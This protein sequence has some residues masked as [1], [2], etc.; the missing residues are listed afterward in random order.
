MRIALTLIPG[1]TALT[2]TLFWRWRR[3]LFASVDGVPAKNR[4]LGLRCKSK[5]QDALVRTKRAYSPRDLTPSPPM[6]YAFLLSTSNSSCSFARTSD[7][8]PPIDTEDTYYN[9]TTTE[10]A[11][12]AA[13]GGLP[14][15]SLFFEHLATYSLVYYAYKTAQTYYTRVKHANKYLEVIVFHFI[16]YD[17]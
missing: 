14:F 13:V 5:I 8:L 6:A 4:K 12:D 15:H 11:A 3:A 10:Q 7:T 9:M 17:Q 1:W 2:E 16:A